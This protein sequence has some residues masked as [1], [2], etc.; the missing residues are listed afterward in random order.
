MNVYNHCQDARRPLVAG[1][2]AL[3]VYSLPVAFSLYMRMAPLLC[4]F[5]AFFTSLGGV[6]VRSFLSSLD[7]AKEFDFPPRPFF[8]SQS[9]P[10]AWDAKNNKNK[11]E[12][13]LIIIPSVFP[14]RGKHAPFRRGKQGGNAPF[15][16]LFCSTRIVSREP[17]QPG[18]QPSGQ[19]IT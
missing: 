2:F 8:R 11:K 6:N 13:R 4:C 10:P 14:E 1:V 16:V 12:R 17:Q 5:C 7:P 9:P 3:P 18:I 19:S 15:S